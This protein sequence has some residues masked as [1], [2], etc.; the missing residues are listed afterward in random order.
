M[1]MRNSDLLTE[2]Q[3]NPLRISHRQNCLA[4]YTVICHADGDA[5]VADDL[6]AALGLSW[7]DARIG[8]RL[9]RRRVA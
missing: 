4:A 1:P 2:G 9:A 8:Q 7:R 6:L 5:A 3:L